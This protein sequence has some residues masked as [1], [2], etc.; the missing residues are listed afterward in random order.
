[1]VISLSVEIILSCSYHERFHW[2]KVFYYHLIL[3]FTLEVYEPIWIF[4][5]DKYFSISSSHH[6]NLSPLSPFA[7]IRSSAFNSSHDCS[8]H[9]GNAVILSLDCDRVVGIVDAQ[10][11]KGCSTVVLAGIC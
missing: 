11:I 9:Q 10:L 7:R 6:S 8:Q 4:S 2:P 1:M 5:G 3:K